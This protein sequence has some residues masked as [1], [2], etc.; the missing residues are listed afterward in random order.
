MDLSQIV[1]FSSQQGVVSIRCFTDKSRGEWSENFHE[2][3]KQH[4]L[5]GTMD[6]WLMRERFSGHPD[7]NLYLKNFYVEEKID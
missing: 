2:I 5:D 1:F 3:K 7:N 6:I 4:L